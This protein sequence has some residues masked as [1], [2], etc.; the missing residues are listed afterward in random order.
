M[1]KQPRHADQAC[2][3]HYYLQNHGTMAGPS[4][5]E[6]RTVHWDSDSQPIRSSSLMNEI[7]NPKGL[8]KVKVEITCHSSVVRTI[9]KNKVI[10]HPTILAVETRVLA[11]QH[12]NSMGTHQGDCLL[13][14][15]A[16]LGAEKMKQISG[17]NVRE[18]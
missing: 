18:G 4:L 3:R 12:S 11:S 7:E 10:D 8:V 6:V 16:K 17:G 9:V 2:Q 13:Y 15:E 14:V 1:E 5:F